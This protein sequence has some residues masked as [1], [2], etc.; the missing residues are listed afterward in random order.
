MCLGKVIG[1][2]EGALLL[3]SDKISRQEEKKRKKEVITFAHLGF[4]YLIIL[5]CDERSDTGKRMDRNSTQL[6]RSIKL[7]GLMRIYGEL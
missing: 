7:A 1:G 2:G 6:F 4:C 5:G 3:G